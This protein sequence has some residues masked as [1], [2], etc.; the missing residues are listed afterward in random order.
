M[1]TIG[2]K[3]AKKSELQ[4]IKLREK[5]ISLRASLL[6]SLGFGCLYF[7]AVCLCAQDSIKTVSLILMRDQQ[8]SVELPP[9]GAVVLKLNDK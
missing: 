1:I 2:K 4:K 5:Q 9:R 7:L 6:I 3:S 8:V